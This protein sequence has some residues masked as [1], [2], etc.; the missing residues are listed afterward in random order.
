[1]PKTKFRTRPKIRTLNRMRGMLARP[2]VTAGPAL[3]QEGFA[4]A[5][6]LAAQAAARACFLFK[7]VSPSAGAF[8]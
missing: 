4:V 7:G 1:M 2:A 8:V 3:F 5:A 6:R